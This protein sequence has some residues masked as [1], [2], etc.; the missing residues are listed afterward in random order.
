MSAS[1][2]SPSNVF[3]IVTI[4]IVEDFSG[5]SLSLALASKDKTRVFVCTECVNFVKPKK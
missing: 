1:L 4:A 3:L 5:P 2:E